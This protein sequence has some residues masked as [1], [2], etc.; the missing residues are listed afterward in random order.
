M[1][2]NLQSR[3]KEIDELVMEFVNS[4][5]DK[6]KPKKEESEEEED[7]EEEEEEE[8]VTVFGLVNDNFLKFHFFL[9]GGRLRRWKEEEA[10]LH[11]QETGRQ[12]EQEG[13]RRFRGQ[14][15]I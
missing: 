10:R 15:A 3:K 6:K 4:K 1:D 13:L 9:T 2:A 5:K 12:E 8:E 7:E 14:R 11:R